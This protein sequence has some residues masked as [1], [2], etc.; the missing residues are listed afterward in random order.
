[1]LINAPKKAGNGFFKQVL[2]I[3]KTLNITLGFFCLATEWEKFNALTAEQQRLLVTNIAAQTGRSSA[4]VWN[5]FYE[6]NPNYKNLTMEQKQAQLQSATTSQRTG[7]GGGVGQV[8]NPTTGQYVE[9]A[10]GANANVP[11]PLP[12]INQI[13][14]QP[15]PTAAQ[16]NEIVTKTFVN[17]NTGQ[18]VTI[19]NTPSYIDNYVLEK[20][21][22]E[23]KSYVGGT[24]TL[25]PDSFFPSSLTALRLSKAKDYV[26][27]G[28]SVEQAVHTATKYDEYGNDLL[29]N[30]DIVFPKTTTSLPQDAMVM[31]TMNMNVSKKPALQFDLSKAL[32]DSAMA[33]LIFTVATTPIRKA[34]EEEYNKAL[35]IAK[36]REEALVNLQMAAATTQAQSNLGKA[37]DDL[38]QQKQA[39]VDA[40]EISV[41]QANTELKTGIENIAAQTNADLQAKAKGFEKTANFKLQLKSAELG[42]EANATLAAQTKDFSLK[43]MGSSFALPDIS[44]KPMDVMAMQVAPTTGL[45]AKTFT[46]IDAALYGIGFGLTTV[47]VTAQAMEESIG[48]AGELGGKAV[49]TSIA[50]YSRVIEMG[51]G[52]YSPLEEERLQAGIRGAGAVGRPMAQIGSYFIL[53][54]TPLMVRSTIGVL[55]SKTPEEA[56]INVGTGFL[57][58]AT[59]KGAL[60]LAGRGE[61]VA[62]AFAEKYAGET[63]GIGQILEESLLAGQGY[64]PETS[65]A[66]AKKASYY[67]PLAEKYAAETAEFA[68]QSGLGL[69]IAG[70]TA[71]DIVPI[72]QKLAS[73]N[74]KEVELGRAQLTDLA[75]SFAGFTIGYKL[76]EL[77][78]TPRAAFVQYGLGYTGFGEATRGKFPTDITAELKP[79]KTVLLLEQPTTELVGTKARAIKETVSTKLAN[80]AE[81]AQFFAE[82]GAKETTGLIELQRERLALQEVRPTK[83]VIEPAQAMVASEAKI[84]KVQTTKFIFESEI[85]LQQRYAFERVT[86]TYDI[87]PISREAKIKLAGELFPAVKTEMPFFA[88]GTEQAFLRKTSK[89]FILAGKEIVIE[90]VGAGTILAQKGLLTALPKEVAFKPF[91]ATEQVTKEITRKAFVDIAK[92]PYAQLTAKETI[93]METE[94]VK[95][96][97]ELTPKRQI[98][99]ER[100]MAKPSAM[101]E[102]TTRTTAKFEFFDVEALAITKGVTEAFTGFA[103][104]I[105]SKII[106]SPQMPEGILGKGKVTAERV[107]LRSE[108]R[109]LYLEIPSQEI[110]VVLVKSF[111]E[112]KAKAQPAKLGLLAELKA[113]AK[114]PA[115]RALFLTPEKPIYGFDAKASKAFYES[116]GVVKAKPVVENIVAQA[117]AAEV[118]VQRQRVVQEK[119]VSAIAQKALGITVGAA[120]TKAAAI[121]AAPAASTMVY[122]L[123]VKATQAQAQK[124]TFSFTP[125]ITQQPKISSVGLVVGRQGGG[126]VTVTREREIVLPQTKELVNETS[127]QIIMNRTITSDI[128]KPVTKEKQKE[129]LEEEQKALIE[130]KSKELYSVRTR[131]GEL[132]VQTQAQQQKVQLQQLN[133]NVSLFV[134]FVPIPPILRIVKPPALPKKPKQVT[135]TETQGPGFVAQVKYKK[136]FETISAPMDEQSALNF[137]AGAVDNSA[138]KTF[139]VVASKQPPKQEY[140]D[141]S[142][143]EKGYKFKASSQPATYIER[144]QYGIDTAGEVRGISAKGWAAKQKKKLLKT[145]FAKVNNKRRGKQ[146]VKTGFWL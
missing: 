66:F 117:K 4:G 138:Q 118:Q 60:K 76:G 109:P 141:Y 26:A 98:T 143:A 27:A 101:E 71:M 88:I 122:A 124:Q 89:G 83:P 110:N 57:L 39:R 52:K 6:Q 69:V 133:F 137:G 63:E 78:W 34:V 15:I 94:G 86:P 23:Q 33:N 49:G 35:T 145:F 18:T 56:I 40:G 132:T 8:Y 58:G 123:P 112:A 80:E 105:K 31:N 79:K 47:N 16:S 62:A 44:Y 130:E 65:L 146:K 29:A 74:P 72:T 10:V 20:G 82:T 106:E 113:E 32:N 96:T 104:K 30:L 45:Y 85:E 135:E 91:E 21:L 55:A 134:P 129:I 54:G 99:A 77:A 41:E 48:Y 142:F 67:L 90:K 3:T 11:A 125:I 1:V 17:P 81:Q 38:L 7:A 43:E 2:L 61:K 136:R 128:S 108:Q 103:S 42:K 37:A 70:K 14:Q 87:L 68:A 13:T 140:A 22:V 95:S 139:R 115:E 92:K 114:T 28:L 24:K 102:F 25:I 9:G 120:I 97:I 5:S 64:V 107:L 51:L 19:R 111:A 116:V 131:L 84:R 12:T 50:G 59:L 121:K 100:I 53:G 119:T 126:T 73:I 127:K 144:N 46:P 93:M 75:T 36:Q